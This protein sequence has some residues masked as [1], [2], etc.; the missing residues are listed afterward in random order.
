[1]II[2]QILPALADPS[3]PYNEQHI[4]VIRSLT[5]I[6]SIIL[7]TDIPG[8]AH[9]T[10]SLFS[11]SF[12][13]LSGPSKAHSG[14]EVSLN[15]EHTLTALLV[16][17]V[18]E[19]SNL[20]DPV[21]DIVLAQFLRAD[22]KTLA[23]NGGPTKG[24]K[25]AVQ[26]EENQATLLL[27][28]APAAYTMA[29]D[30]CNTCH[31]KMAR[32]VL[33]YFSS[34]LLNVSMIVSD[35]KPSKKH[36]RQG[37][38][39]DDDDETMQDLAAEELTDSRKAHNLLR[40]LWRAA[41]P[42]LQDIIP[43]LE[44][45]LSTENLPIR[46]MAVETVGDM[47]S[48]IGTAGPP[49]TAVLDPAAYP[50]QSLPDA[51]KAQPYHFLLTPTSAMAFASKYHSTYQEF[52]RR[53]QDK[54]AV[55]RAAWATAVGRIILTSA[56]GVG[57]DPEDE[58]A[59]LNYLA[60]SLN[61]AD[62]RVRLSAIKV[63]GSFP[64]ND[65]VSKL[66][67][68][69]RVS[70]DGSLLSNL[71]DRVK[72]LKPT[73]R[74]EAIKFLARLWGVAVGAIAEG[75]EHTKELLGS[76]PSKLFAVVYVNDPETNKLLDRLL[77]ESLVPLSYPPSKVRQHASN[78]A[79]QNGG[80][81]GQQG[82]LD[83]DADKI[84]TERIL[85]LVQSLEPKSRRGF[86]AKQSLQTGY[87]QFMLA[88]LQ[89]CED[90]NGGTVDTASGKDETQVKSKMKKLIDHFGDRLPESQRAKD[91]LWKFAKLHDRR[92]YA[93]IR[94]CCAPESEWSKIRKS[95]NEFSK[96]VEDSTS[97]SSS[98]SML[99]T[100]LTLIYRSSVLIYNRS[101]VPAIIQFSRTDDKGLGSTA[102]E[103]LGEISKNKSEVFKAHVEE[104][105]RT[106]ESEAPS[107]TKPHRPDAIHDLKACADFA[108][109]CTGDMPQNRKFFTSLMSYIKH[110][111]PQAA[112]YAVII[113]LT[114]ASK[115]EMYAKDVF[116]SCTKDF[117][118]GHPGFLSRLAALSQLALLG[119]NYIESNEADTVVDIAINKVL[120]NFDEAFPAFEEADDQEAW[121]DEPGEHSAAKA[122]ALQI[123]I[124][125]LRALPEQESI[126]APSKPVYNF[127]NKLIHNSGQASSK[128]PVPQADASRL[129]LQAA[130]HLLKLSCERRFNDCLTPRAFNELAVMAQDP[131][132]QVREPF[133]RQLMKYLGQNRLPKRFYTPLF[134]L[135]F[136]PV[137]QLKS[138]TE[139]WLRSRAKAF[140]LKSDTT[141]E[142]TFARFISLLAHHEDFEA[143]GDPLREMAQQIIFY[144][145]TV[146]TRENISLIFYVAQR[147]KS[148]SDGID[149]ASTNI[150]VISDLAQAIIT[151]WDERQDWNMQTWPGRINL[152]S[153]IFAAMDSHDR[154]RQVAS[155]MFVPEDV[156]NDLDAIVQEGLKS[157]KGKR[158][159]EAGT[160][161]IKKRARASSEKGPT[162]KKAKVGKTPKRNSTG[163]NRTKVAAAAASSPSERRRSGRS[164][165]TRNYKE[166][167]DEEDELD[168][169]ED[170]KMNLNG[171]AK[172]GKGR[173]G[174]RTAKD[175]EI[176]DISDDA[177]SS[178]M[179][180]D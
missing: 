82:L 77:F 161:R 102:H 36:Q 122:W 115:K 180:E 154:S 61:D 79:S 58:R 148:V 66:G 17:L 44:T 12:D 137:L 27:K 131:L 45:E 91:D 57:I 59:L 125:R 152:P 116:S 145:R 95:I 65:V 13:I 80:K 157:K 120:T 126:E 10:E 172:K 40:E 119:S 50:S 153:G 88:F 29:Q 112:K 106:L 85:L 78:G 86:M 121:S 53:R 103:I 67:K 162:P 144:L 177:E 163:L 110:G 108:R 69:G 75:S 104:L 160:T 146:A 2:T 107:A 151:L 23:G 150:Y 20:P 56:G 15:V 136:E 139:T 141:L 21:I 47:I 1:M 25:R 33:R 55:V 100:M 167:S 19:A 129:R 123:L 38:D 71:A 142:L 63:I 24:K 111:Q 138:N 22:P 31:D 164:A 8:S 26:L 130:R 87:A 97:S 64:Y 169:D 147:V 54:A 99:D 133:V 165:N 166:K 83:L 60:D 174:V 89:T 84:R 90:Y 140:A 175:K 76:I 32:Y 132:A 46:L 37:T 73:V 158:K 16:M 41:P 109:K 156:M 5:E 94:F 34:I 81:T 92:N 143:E 171:S 11:T 170:V 42:V 168:D 118:Y 93:L 35:N 101:H 135:A 28:E 124:N 173:A 62:E 68:G 96:R 52:L 178:E 134:L 6:K 176:F 51:I 149:K 113:L 117:K 128:Y 39:V 114:A 18:D 105:C 74:I 72:D 14:E 4:A 48:G 7:I 43:Q 155:K 127:L 179:E 9:L 30:I 70:E 159:A 3:S 98:S 49:Q